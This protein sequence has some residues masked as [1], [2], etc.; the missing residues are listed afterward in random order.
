MFLGFSTATLGTENINDENLGLNLSDLFNLD[1]STVSRQK[2]DLFDAPGVISVLKHDEI[3]QIGAITLKELLLRL[4]GVSQATCPLTNRTIINIRGNQ[5]KNNSSHILFLINGR[6]VRE[7]Q[8]GGVNSDLIESFPVDAIKRLEIIRGPGSVLYGSDAFSGVINIITK[9]PDN[10]D[11]NIRGFYGLNVAGG[12]SG[13]LL[14][15]LG[16]IEITLAGRIYNK[17]NWDVSYERSYILY[18]SITHISEIHDSLV[19]DTIEDKGPGIFVNMNYKNLSLSGSVLKWST[20]GTQLPVTIENI[21]YFGDIGYS[22]DISESWNSEVSLTGTRTEI[23]TSRNEFIKRNSNNIL[24]ENVHF[25]NFFSNLNIITG[26][27]FNYIEGLEKEILYEFSES[28]YWY[29]TNSNFDNYVN[30]PDFLE[31]YFDYEKIES[32]ISIGTKTSVSAFFQADFTLWDKLK[33]IGGIQLNKPK[34]IKKHISP[35]A[36]LIWRPLQSLS[37]KTLYSEAFRTPSINELFMNYPGG[38]HGNENLQPEIIKTFDFGFNYQNAKFM[39]GTNLFYSLLKD[40]IYPVLQNDGYTR[41][42]ENMNNFS[43][44]GGE[45]ECKYNINRNFY[46]NTSLLYQKNKNNEGDKDVVPVSNINLKGGIS[47]SNDRGITIN[48]FNNY[49]G[50]I[51]DKWIGEHQNKDVQGEYNI[52]DIHSNVNIGKLFNKTVDLDPSIILKINNLFDKE[53]W[54]YELGGFQNGSV[55]KIRGREIFIGCNISF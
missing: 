14:F 3:Q 25:F 30:D 12:I 34:E 54:L 50:K 15:N 9:T 43:F 45:I 32:L 36:G 18:D 37:F 28:S 51:A 6:P 55:P 23:N 10:F 46:F 31:S 7:V 42:Y 20:R 40:I 17:G 35:R 27:T 5:I 24:F 41:I 29:D 13:N 22:L 38:L 4:P 1:V 19:R 44:I 49:N 52:F 16:D 8:E 2:E 33:F 53:V 21:K 11:S 48:L 26:G 47:Y 39:I